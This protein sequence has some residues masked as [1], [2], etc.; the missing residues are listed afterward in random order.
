MFEAVSHLLGGL[1]LFLLGMSLMS[2]GLKSFAGDSLRR[3]LL[4]FTSR[5]IAAFLSGMGI[6][7]IIQSSSAT[8][9][10]TIGFVS[11]GVLPF[12]Q[13]I[14]VLMGA[15][16]GTTSTGWIVS[17]IGLN[18]SI[19]SYA[20][21]FVAAGA[22]IRVFLKGRAN[23][24]G[25][26]VA[27]FGLIF[28]GIG[29]MQQGMGALTKDF[30]PAVLPSA[31]LG[32]RALVLGIGVILTVL[33]QSC[34]AVMAANMTALSTGVI[35]FEQATS[36]AIGAAI[37]TSVTAAV[38]GLG[39]SLH[40]RRTA[41]SIVIF[42]VSTG[43]LAFGLQPLLVGL[44]AWLH[45]NWGLEEG[46]VSLAVFHS[47][48]IAIGVAIGLPLVRPYARLIERLLPEREA[49][50][51][52]YL[53]RSQLGLPEV[54]LEAVRRSLVECRAALAGAA[55][56]ALQGTPSRPDPAAVTDAVAK[57]LDSLQ[58]YL[59]TIDVEAG[60]HGAEARRI[61]DIHIIDHLQQLV[62]AI[63][64][65]GLR[66]GSARL[67][68][69]ETRLANA[70]QALAAGARPEDGMRALSAEIAAFR[71]SERPVI[72]ADAARAGADSSATLAELDVLRWLDR[73]AYHFARIEAHFVQSPEARAV[74]EEFLV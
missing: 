23:H 28:F 25:T 59:A 4:A 35:N 30:D 18:V 1:G 70:L 53:D 67:G 29:L 5:P 71:R 43:V 27:G 61:S 44:L 62:I 58:T 74:P 13:S 26:A 57:A 7:A 60:N 15:S 19:S 55:A 48:F 73:T 47:M 40:A 14:G 45:R 56:A 9:L 38:A 65:R 22:A 51:T 2:D 34:S 24:L 11:A 37:G 69:W 41:L 66:H 10:M 21:L 20:L 42:N 16:L 54:A 46:A 12:A 8:T 36:L 31:G 32:A 63:K 50:F 64:P 39:G 6:T 68:P 33:M 3:T 17:L 52:R 49:G 72:L